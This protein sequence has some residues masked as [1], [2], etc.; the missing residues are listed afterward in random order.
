VRALE[1][2]IITD[3]ACI[4]AAVKRDLQLLIGKYV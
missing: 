2:A 4:P 3:R 1:H